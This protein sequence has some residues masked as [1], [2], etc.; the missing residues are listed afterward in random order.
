MIRTDSKIIQRSFEYHYLFWA[1]SNCTGTVGVKCVHLFKKWI[2]LVHSNSDSGLSYH[3]PAWVFT[4]MVV[5][6]TLN[7]NT[8]SCE[9]V[10]NPRKM[11]MS[12]NSPWLIHIVSDVVVNCFFFFS[13]YST[14]QWYAVIPVWWYGS[15]YFCITWLDH[16]ML[17]WVFSGI[18][19]GQCTNHANWYCFQ[20]GSFLSP[21]CEK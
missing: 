3:V 14:L 8:S 21:I 13:A 17:T 6:L 16:Q 7:G 9:D 19:S 12:W 1:I 10:S 5:V 20:S 18:I 15:G 11:L 4:F 2:Y